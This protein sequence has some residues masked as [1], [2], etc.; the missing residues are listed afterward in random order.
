VNLLKAALI[1]SDILTTVS[2]RYS[3]EIQTA[4]FGCGLEGI[5]RTRSQD[6]FG[7]LNGIDPEEWNPATDPDLAA[8]Y[9]SSDMAGKAACK[10]DLQRT[11]GLKVEPEAPLF[12]CIS[13]LAEQKGMDLLAG[14]LDAI[15]DSGGQLVL[16]GTGDPPLEEQFEAAAAAHPGRVAAVIGFDDPLSHKIE[17]GA[18]LFLMPSRYEP[19]GLNQMYSLRY[20]TIPIVRA[21]GGLDDTVTSFDRKTGEGI[22]LKFEAATADALALAIYRG[23]ALYRDPA[24]W[25]RLRANAMRDDFSWDRSARRYEA[26]YQKAARR[27]R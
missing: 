1:F 21:T 9:S 13:R 27:R 20:G 15:L 19:C 6:V 4:E 3:R 26:L 12:G 22:G 17:A 18:D 11:V 23:A 25:R 7:I 16:L 14:A 5:L 10:E 24:A 2:E 8:H